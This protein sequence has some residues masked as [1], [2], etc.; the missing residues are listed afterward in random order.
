MLQVNPC[1]YKTA[2]ARRF[3]KLNKLWIPVSFSRSKL[4]YLV[5]NIFG[6]HCCLSLLIPKKSTH[7]RNIK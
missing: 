6:L 7:H 2:L 1:G 5:L 3:K 4:V